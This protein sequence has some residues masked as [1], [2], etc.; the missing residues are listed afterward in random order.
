M[1]ASAAALAASAVAPTFAVLLLSLSVVGLTT[2]TGQ[3]LTPL[4]GDL[5][6]EEHRGAVVGTVASGILTGILLS[7][8]I[9][10]L[11][12]DAFGWRA[13]YVIA[14]VVTLGLAA[15]LARALPV[16]PPR[17]RMR[18]GA[19]LRSV[20]QTVGRHR[21]A[22]VTLVLEATAFCVFT[23]FWTGLTFLLSSPPYSY[24]VSQ[25]GLVGLAGL[26]GALVARRAG[27]LHDRGWSVPATG[28]ALGLTLVSL[29]IAGLGR[30]SIVLVLVA[31]VLLDMA[32]QAVNVL[33][34]TRLFAIDAGARSRLNTAFVTSNFV[35]GAV[36]STLAAVLW[37]QDGW[38][39]V[40]VGGAALT[41][42]ALAV[43]WSQRSHPWPSPNGDSSVRAHRYLLRRPHADA[44]HRSPEAQMTPVLVGRARVGDDVLEVQPAVD[45]LEATPAAALDDRVLAAPMLLYA[46][47]RVVLRLEPVRRREPA[48]SAAVERAD[49]DL[50]TALQVHAPWRRLGGQHIRV[51]AALDAPGQHET[52]IVV[53]TSRRA[54][55][56]DRIEIRLA[57]DLRRRLTG[58]GTQE[59]QCHH[60]TSQQPEW[61][62][63]CLHVVVRSIKQAPLP[64][65]SLCASPDPVS[66]APLPWLDL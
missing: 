45:S 32:V 50:P 62:S 16:V 42:V 63:S 35:G 21:S 65:L 1:V 34:Q 48:R 17:P 55:A 40:T 58:D 24:S 31:V 2:V 28:A 29:G 14:A 36:G 46:A 8:T 39:A 64:A 47:F 11:I 25:I 51:E 4:A 19:L 57:P 6:S 66:M 38:P 12:A 49:D 22:Q 5:A 10:G 44:P 23:L 26:A 33:N 53:V 20:F 56:L 54:R 52:R 30:T 37:H 41:V 27:T 13:V 60:A 59:R 61:S 3:L 43:W 18:Y 7:R 9:S 15:V